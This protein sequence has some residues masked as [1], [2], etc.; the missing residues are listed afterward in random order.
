MLRTSLKCIVLTPKN[1]CVVKCLQQKGETLKLIKYD[2]SKVS[3]LGY[4]LFFFSFQWSFLGSHVW[5]HPLTTISYLV[6]ISLSYSAF[7]H[8]SSHSFLVKCIILLEH[9][10]LFHNE[11]SSFIFPKN[12][13]IPFY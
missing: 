13:L 4:L 9:I 7:Q 3:T 1:K 11:S 6:V 8:T 2:L 5:V 12:L 10:V